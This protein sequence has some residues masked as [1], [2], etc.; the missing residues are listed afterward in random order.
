[1]PTFK[2]SLT[3][4]PIHSSPLP[5]SLSIYNRARDCQISNFS[6][7]FMSGLPQG[8]NQVQTRALL[9]TSSLHF[10]PSPHLPIIP[11]SL[12]GLSAI[13]PVTTFSLLALAT[14]SNLYDLNVSI[15]HLAGAW[16]SGL[17]ARPGIWLLAAT[18]WE[19]PMHRED[20]QTETLSLKL[21]RWAVILG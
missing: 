14:I 17:P 18:V 12:A 9:L 21:L 13:S 2:R 3:P 11:R 1:M 8:D 16:V 5:T 15:S 7:E 10:P 6:D 19:C 4:T 20:Q